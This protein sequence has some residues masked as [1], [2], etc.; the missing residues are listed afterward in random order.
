L[1]FSFGSFLASRK[2][3]GEAVS[4]AGELLIDGSFR[5]S[6]VEEVVVVKGSGG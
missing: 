1:I 3:E 6:G 2:N 4:W 5:K